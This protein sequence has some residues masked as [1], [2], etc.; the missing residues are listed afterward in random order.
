MNRY[1]DSP[2]ATAWICRHLVESKGTELYYQEETSVLSDCKSPNKLGFLLYFYNC[3]GRHTT[4]YA[5][6]VATLDALRAPRFPSL[7]L[8]YPGREGRATGL[9]CINCV[10]DAHYTTH[11]LHPVPSCKHQMGQHAQFV[12]FCLGAMGQ[13]LRADG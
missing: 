11:F 8:V 3:G 9:H 2:P 10:M 13:G 7:A 12:F 6:R 5:Y 1:F 4:Y